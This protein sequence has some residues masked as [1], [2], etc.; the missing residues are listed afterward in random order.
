MT[1]VTVD[2]GYWTSTDAVPEVAKKLDYMRSSDGT[3]EVAFAGGYLPFGYNA[4][5]QKAHGQRRP[6]GIPL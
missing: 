3:N 4:T 6:M 5:A 2:S 1:G